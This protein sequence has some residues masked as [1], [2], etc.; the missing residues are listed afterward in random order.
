MRSQIPSLF[1]LSIALLAAFALSIIIGS[2]AIHWQDMN[3]MDKLILHEIRLPRAVLAMLVGASLGLSGA[4]IQG[5][6]RNPLAEPGLLGITNGA[7]LGAITAIY[8]GYT[9]ISDNFRY[10][11]AM[12]GA[13]GAVFLTT[14]LAGK[15]TSTQ[16]LVLAGIA[17]SSLLGACV[18]LALNL[19]PNPF[20]S[21]EVIFWLLG[22]LQNHTWPQILAALPFI[23]AG[24]ALLLSCRRGL[25][26]LSLGDT[27]A[28]SLGVHL[29]HLRLKL[30]L[31]IA[32][33]VGASTAIVGSIGFVGLVVPHLLR[34]FATYQPSR[35]LPLSALGG[36][37]LLL[38]ADAMVRLIPTSGVE[39]QVGVITAFIGAPF[40]LVLLFR[41]P[42]SI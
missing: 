34:P 22:S 1:Y 28:I 42:R 33:A 5:Y 30:A 32:L 20:A 9:L 23:I 16:G 6:L 8:G 35:L 21:M 10:G 14:L 17:V 39:L 2:H 12:L 15:R 4:A 24:C 29:S 40:L 37:I 31:G 36:A 41:Q 25:D 38:L 7:A 19:A 18:S 26:A 27:T 3:A 11:L 13:L